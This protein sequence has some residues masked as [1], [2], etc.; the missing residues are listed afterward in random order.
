MAFTISDERRIALSS[1]FDCHCFGCIVPSD[2][3]AKLICHEAHGYEGTSVDD[4]RCNAIFFKRLADSH[5]DFLIVDGERNLFGR[6][7][8]IHLAAQSLGDNSDRHQS[9][10]MTG[11]AS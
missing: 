3:C 4:N 5:L 1:G 6:A 7:V 11:A 10:V 2:V 9:S 8:P